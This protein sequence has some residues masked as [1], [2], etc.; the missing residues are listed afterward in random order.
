MDFFSLTM[1]DLYRAMLVMFRT[2]AVMMSVPVFGHASIPRRLRVWFVMLIA[3]LIIP[4]SF[5]IET[6]LPRTLVGLAVVILTEIAIGFLLGFAVMTVFAAVQFAGHIIGLQMGLA[7]AN[8]VDPMGAGQISIIGEYYYLFS[9]VIFL[10]INGHH[11]VINAI[12]RSF[13]MIPLGGAVFGEPVQA[14]VIDFAFGVFVFGIKLA[15][16]VLI[17]LFI[18]NAVLGI[19]AR[20]V[21]QMNVFIVGFPLAIGVG[22]ALIG[23][24]FPAFYMLI[25]KMFNGLERD[26]AVIIT[27]LAR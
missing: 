3:Y 9:L 20:T 23:I 17:T 4:V 26:F 27:T 8:I 2:G 14:M 5:V 16:P 1:A 12:V 13:E 11:I 24:S 21:P 25:N 19:V 6:D 15:A 18:T 22:L 10:L 7:V